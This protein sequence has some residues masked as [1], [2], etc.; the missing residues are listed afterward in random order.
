[1]IEVGKYDASVVQA[2]TLCLICDKTIPVY[3]FNAPPQIC[4]ECKKRIKKILY[5]PEVHTE[6]DCGN[7]LQHVGYSQ[8]ACGYNK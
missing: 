2:C 4:D 1:M 6:S 8:E 5:P 3:Y 7:L